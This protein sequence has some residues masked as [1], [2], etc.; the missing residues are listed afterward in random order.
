MVLPP[1][2]QKLDLYGCGDFSAWSPMCCL[3][4]LTSLKSLSMS[5]CKG[6]VSIPG[7]LWRSNLKSLWK[8]KIEECPDL[9]SIGGPEAIADIYRVHIRGCRKLME[10]QQ[11]RGN[12]WD[13]WAGPT[14]HIT[15]IAASWWSPSCRYVLPYILASTCDLGSHEKK[16]HRQLRLLVW[17]IKPFRYFIMG[18]FYEFWLDVIVP[19]Y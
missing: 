19:R 18:S 10:I 11:P 3:E 17:E 1:S 15:N 4:N 5:C 8:L 9:V 2:L 7:D 6:I 16:I 13:L 14:G 12:W